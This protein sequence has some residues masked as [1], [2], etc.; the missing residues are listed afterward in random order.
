MKEKEIMIRLLTCTQE[1]LVQQMQLVPPHVFLFELVG[2]LA[3]VPGK[4]FDRAQVYP[5]GLG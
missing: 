3:E 1:L 5:C 4:V 2:R